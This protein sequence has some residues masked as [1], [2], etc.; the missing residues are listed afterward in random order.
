M[1]ATRKAERK[2]GCIEAKTQLP[3]LQEKW[4]KA[5]P[6]KDGEVKPLACGVTSVVAEE[7]GW[8][9]PYAK[10]ILETWKR[11]EAY[12]RAVLTYQVRIE[13]DGTPAADTVS[14][15]ARASAK[16]MLAKRLA[17][18][19]RLVEQQEKRKLQENT[20]PDDQG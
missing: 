9:R 7:F 5:F 19:K 12:C 20:R 10:A 14:E 18:K 16:E 1:N 17:K 4:P 15:A 13:L 6:R 11:R 8:S 2:R 3:L